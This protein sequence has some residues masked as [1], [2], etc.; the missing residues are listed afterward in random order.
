MDLANR[1]DIDMCGYLIELLNDQLTVTLLEELVKQ[2]HD[3][4][5]DKELD[6]DEET[7]ARPDVAGVP[8]HPG[9]DV[10]DGLA[11]GDHH[12]EQLLGAVEQG[13]VL[14]GVPDLDEL[15]AGEQLHDEPRG[16]DG[17][18]A[19]LHEGASV[20]GQDDSDPVEGVS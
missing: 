17:G 14:W 19:E 10:H 20:G 18:D 11:H 8:V 13:A 3:E 2:Q 12:P 16:D 9:Q 4:P 1:P 5:G 7:H 15:G 6:D